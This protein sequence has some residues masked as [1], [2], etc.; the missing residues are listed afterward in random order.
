[1]ETLYF[2]RRIYDKVH[3][4]MVRLTLEEMDV[5]NSPDFQRLRWICQTGL[6]KLIWPSATHTRFEH[7]IGVVHSAQQMLDDFETKVR[8]YVG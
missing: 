1:M 8:E 5:I 7:S 6:L 2:P 3:D 4:D